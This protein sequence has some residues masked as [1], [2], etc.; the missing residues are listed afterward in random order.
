MDSE[1]E[2][3]KGGIEQHL[4]ERTSQMLLCQGPLQLVGHP[5][6]ADKDRIGNL[7]VDNYLVA[8]IVGIAL[9]DI[10]LVD[11][12]EQVVHE[13][14]AAVAAVGGVVKVVWLHLA[15]VVRP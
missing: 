2:L 3:D 7:V 8:V 1:C 13:C 11:M 6:A 12:L 15:L 4:V 14:D 10:V 9:V 5:S